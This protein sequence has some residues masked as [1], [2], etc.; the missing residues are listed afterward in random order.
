[1]EIPVLYLH[2]K[3]GAHEKKGDAHGNDDYI[4]PHRTKQPAPNLSISYL[5]VIILFFESDADGT[6]A[7]ES[8]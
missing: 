7:I 2:D 4:L 8:I 1:M 3:Y 5:E 6:E